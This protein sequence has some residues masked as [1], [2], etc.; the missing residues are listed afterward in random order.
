MPSTS[1][2]QA[3]LMAA[4]AHD[5][6]FAKKTG[7]PVKVAKEFNRADVQKKQAS[8]LRKGKKVEKETPAQEKRES[9]AHEA[10]ESPDYERAEHRA[11]RSGTGSMSSAGASVGGGM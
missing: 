3:R 6:A 8:M 9:A 7:V 1:P 10:A 5:P 11:M 2:A 4:A